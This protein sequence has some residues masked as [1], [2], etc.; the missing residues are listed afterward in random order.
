MTLKVGHNEERE[1]N[2]A[3]GIFIGTPTEQH[4]EHSAELLTR[5]GTGIG[6]S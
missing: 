2:E 5:D 1:V 3:L 4:L 6:S